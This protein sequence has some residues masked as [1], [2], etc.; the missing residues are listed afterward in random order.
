MP[1]RPTRVCFF[2]GPSVNAADVHAIFGPVGADLTVLPPVQQGDLLRLLDDLP[3]VIAIVDGFFFQTPSVLHKEILFAME[4]GTRVLGAASMGALRAAE[5]DR[6]GM[7]GVGEIYQW[8]RRRTID[9]DDEVA[10]LHGPAADGFRALSEPLVNLRH[11]AVR[12]RSRGVISA[13]LARAF[14]ATA[15]ELHFAERSYDR[16]CQ[17]LE[18]SGVAAEEVESLRQFLR[19]EAVDLKREDALALARTIASRIEGAQPWPDHAPVRTSQTVFFHLSRREYEGTGSSGEFPPDTFVFSLYKLL[20]PSWPRLF[21]RVVLRC[22]A[23]EEANH[24]G[25]APADDDALVAQYCRSRGIESRGARDRWLVQ[26]GLVLNDLKE[27]LRQ[28]DLEA[29]ILGMVRTVDD[30]PRSPAAS[31]RQVLASVAQRTGLDERQLASLPFMPPGIPWESPFLRELKF[32]GRFTATRASAQAMARAVAEISTW[33]P[34]LAES[35]AVERLDG[36]AAERWNVDPA[37][38]ND[39]LAARGFASYR[40]FVE[41]ARVAYLYEKLAGS[42]TA[43]TT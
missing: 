40:E 2:L 18:R 22:L 1:G 24:R 34:G 25:L 35:L 15:R 21:R 9:G 26:R 19:R 37:S 42:R 14:I 29:Q 8:Y 27:V 39:A 28:R 10:V 5:L 3:E 20:A 4:R 30:A 32:Q 12:A 17:H 23:V 33:A 13:R 7:E 6:L 16:V 38:L 11:N 31:Y 41:V 36:W 43:G